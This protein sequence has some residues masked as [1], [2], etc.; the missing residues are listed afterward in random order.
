M[1]T[2]A[3][4]FRRGWVLCSG[5]VAGGFGLSAPAKSPQAHLDVVQ[6]L[7]KTVW[8]HFNKERK[9]KRER[10][11]DTKKRRKKG[12]QKASKQVRG[13]N[14]LA[15]IPILMPTLHSLQAPGKGESCQVQRSKES[16]QRLARRLWGSG[17]A[18][19]WLRA[20]ESRAGCGAGVTAALQVGSA[21]AWVGDTD[22]LRLR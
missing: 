6:E 5:Q 11:K 10:K 13:T 1:V 22:G 15:R 9:S 19:G 12:R 2:G 4:G 16:K 7:S 21:P 3:E 20:G 14:C 18:W 8:I 17:A